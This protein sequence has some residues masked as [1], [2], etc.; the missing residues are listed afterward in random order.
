VLRLAVDP[1][2]AKELRLF[3][4]SGLIATTVPHRRGIW[5]WN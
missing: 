4:L 2:A 3:G 1:P 5:V